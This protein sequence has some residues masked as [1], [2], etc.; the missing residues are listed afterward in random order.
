[1]V[2]RFLAILELFREGAVAFEQLEAMG[3]LRVRWTA[4]PG[5]MIGLQLDGY[6]GMPAI[7]DSASENDGIVSDSPPEDTGVE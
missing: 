4:A 3:E 1:M 2:A 7:A 6:D 5:A